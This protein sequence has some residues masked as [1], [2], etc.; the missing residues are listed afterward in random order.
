MAELY[1]NPKAVGT[2]DSTTPG[3]WEYRIDLTITYN[4]NTTNWTV[5]GKV[6]RAGTTGCVY[7]KKQTG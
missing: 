6:Y 3:D 4:K 7:S 2:D 5:E 1:S